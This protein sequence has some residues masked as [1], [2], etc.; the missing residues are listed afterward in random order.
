MYLQKAYKLVNHAM[1][2]LYRNGL[3]TTGKVVGNEEHYFNRMGSAD[4]ANAFLTFWITCSN[5]ETLLPPMC[6]VFGILPY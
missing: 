3:F 4:L 1:Q 6:S 2:K 5:S